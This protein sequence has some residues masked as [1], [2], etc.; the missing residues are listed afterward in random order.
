MP[1]IGRLGD[2]SYVAADV[3]GCPAC[4][5][6][7]VGPAITGSGDV[8]VNNKPALRVGDQGIHSACCGANTW[9]AVSGSRSVMINHQPAHRLGDQ[10]RHCGG[11][12]QLIEASSDVL[13]GD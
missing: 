11:M 6:T 7:A 10:D 12:G 4:A 5:H 8:L 1:G 3:H 2:K 9:E 13:V